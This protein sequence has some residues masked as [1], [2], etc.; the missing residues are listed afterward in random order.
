MNQRF[1]RLLIP[2]VCIMGLISLGVFL[3]PE[4]PLDHDIQLTEEVFT[5]YADFYSAENYQDSLLTPTSFFQ[6]SSKSRP[7]LVWYWPGTDVSLRQAIKE[8]T[9]I[10]REGFGGV[11]IQITGKGLPPHQRVA[12][13]RDPA[14]LFLLQQISLKAEQFGLEI[15]WVIGPG[16]PAEYSRGQ[17]GLTWGES[18]IRGDQTVSFP[19][20]QPG[21][22]LGHRLASL[23]HRDK[24]QD[25][26]WLSWQPDSS[27]LLGLWAGKPRSDQR[28]ATF[29][30]TTDGI[31]LDPDSTWSII[32]WVKGDSL[33]GWE[34]PKGPWKIIALY[35]TDLFLSPF[36][37][38]AAFR[39]SV[40]DPYSGQ[41][42][43]QGIKTHPAFQSIPTDSMTGRS[44]RTQFQATVADRLL[45]ENTM[46]ISGIDTFETS[47]FPLLLAQ[48]LVHHTGASALHL[49]RLPEY[50]LGAN[51]EA[52][53]KH[54]EEWLVS[55]QL[56]IGIDSL[57]NT[58]HQAGYASKLVLNDW[59]RGWFDCASQVDIPGFDA[60]ISDGNRLAASLVCD[61]AYYGGKR[62]VT[63][64]VGQTPEMAYANTPQVLKTQIDR[65]LFTGA[66]EIA[67]HGKPY[68]HFTNNTVWD[69]AT[70]HDLIEINH[71][72]QYVEANPFQRWW[73]N[74]WNYT[75]RLQYLSQ[76]GRQQTDLLILYPFSEFPMIEV[77]SIFSLIQP[78]LPTHLHWDRLSTLSQS[79]LERKTDSL[80][81]WMYSIS[82]FIQDLEESGFSWSWMSEKGIREL[83]EGKRSITT[84]YPELKA[85]IIPEKGSIRLTTAQAIERLYD[86]Q[87]LPVYLLGEDRP[88]ARE[89]IK[90]DSSNMVIA[91]IFRSFELPFPINTGAQLIQS[92]ISAKLAPHLAFTTP[93]PAI[94]QR[95]QLMQ[96]GSR[97]LWLI[98]LAESPGAVSIVFGDQKGWVL[99]PETG[100]AEQFLPNTEGVTTINLSQYEN[101]IFWLGNSVQWP[102]SL[103]RESSWDK[104]PWLEQMP[105]ATFET[106]DAWEWA[107][108]Y[109]KETPQ[110]MI[111]PDTGLWNWREDEVL[112]FYQGEVSYTLDLMLEKQE[113]EKELILDLG[114][115][116]D[117]VEVQ[118]NTH[119]LP[120]VSW[121]PFRYN[122]TDYLH[123]GLNTLQ[124]W[125]TNAERNEKIG[126]KMNGVSTL[127][128]N[129]GEESELRPA[130]MQGP[131]QL[132]RI[133][134]PR[135]E[136]IP[137]M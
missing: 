37:K 69:P 102:D 34:A 62:K 35:E 51:D 97:L 114:A 93:S 8:L 12:R 124:I 22:P 115:V 24:T 50:L 63:S 85:I 36:D 86:E 80:V 110:I 133:P 60:N 33:I 28:S 29:W 95:S 73:P 6:P 119:S 75:S 4:E 65:A 89:L 5:T 21:I 116:Y 39:E 16:I 137:E 46:S 108:D 56:K 53:R 117:A 111:L 14:W 30:T 129:R 9:W 90:P 126:A 84:L 57:S 104:N 58:M 47:L 1:L 91:H 20:P 120:L 136:Q 18:H 42:L 83:A 74:L 59:D 107:V 54:Y 71:G 87:N 68:Q 66:T 109:P 131:V 94:R 17:H 100:L 128:W 122:I 48:P 25:Q 67:V 92:L 113:L 11:E 43:S 134:E 118:V 32:D 96:D 82:P 49:N 13:F 7:W 40:I 135:M 15:D 132:W 99:D 106:L 19:L 130:G 125:V 27:R 77:D 81:S 55:Q 23:L 103:R 123:P 64:Y 2:T 121:A 78:P 88:T 112:Q 26:D 101:K 72:G 10:S 52:F 79:L 76:L 38:L 31:E 44:I 41:D 70:T 127:T 3:T 98:N 61:G 45:P 105:G